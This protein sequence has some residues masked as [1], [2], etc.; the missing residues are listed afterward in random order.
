M[1]WDGMI[2]LVFLKMVLLVLFED[3]T[4]ILLFVGFFPSRGATIVLANVV[5]Q[6]NALG[7]LSVGRSYFELP[8]TGHSFAR[9]QTLRVIRDERKKHDS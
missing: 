7:L 8:Y 2:H 6:H 1:E 3:F 4:S 9:L 5:P